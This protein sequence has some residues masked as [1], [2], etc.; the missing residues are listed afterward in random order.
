M[1][2]KD[3]VSVTPIA[4]GPVQLRFL[5]YA[6]SAGALLVIWLH[7]SAIEGKYT[8]FSLI[9]TYVWDAPYV[10]FFVVSGFVLTFVFLQARQF[11]PASFL[12]R[13][14]WRIYPTYWEFCLLLLPLYVWRPDM[15]NGSYGRP[16]L[17]AS[18][19]MLPQPQMP[20]VAVGWTM[21]Y[22]LFFYFIFVAGMVALR[23]H[24][25]LLAGLWA[26]AIAAGHGL[27]AINAWYTVLFSP[28][29]YFFI[30][31]MVLG[32]IY[33]RRHSRWDLPHCGVLLEIGNATYSIYLSHVMVASLA[34]RLWLVATSILRF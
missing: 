23:G 24:I 3:S 8:S 1:P 19:L 11:A 32:W 20:L 33:V 18:F 7:L 16:S 28:L 27:I 30:L 31:G 14:L 12:L 15:I 29:N 17:I 25:P 21:V 2:A 4:S 9:G 5:Q 13:R 26:I 10:I 6:R 34:G 22:E